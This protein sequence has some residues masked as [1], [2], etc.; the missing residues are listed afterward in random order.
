MPYP[1]QSVNN[2]L[3]CMLWHTAEKKPA[4]TPALPVRRHAA[5]DLTRTRPYANL[6]LALGCNEC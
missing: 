3:L 2:Y 1:R 4:G 6:L 5:T